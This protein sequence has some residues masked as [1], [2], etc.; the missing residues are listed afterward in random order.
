MGFEDEFLEP[1][2]HSPYCHFQI[3][4]RGEVEWVRYIQRE[5]DLIHIQDVIEIVQKVGG[6]VVTDHVPSRESVE[7]DRSYPTFR[8]RS[9]SGLL[10]LVVIVIGVI[11]GGVLDSTSVA[12]WRGHFG[13]DSVH[14]VRV[15]FQLFC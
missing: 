11:V 7:R 15:V 3:G 12:V 1:L 9:R 10:T 13:I 5:I 8:W 14:S 6:P 2:G 4:F